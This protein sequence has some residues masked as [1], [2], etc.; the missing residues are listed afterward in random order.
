MN[1]YCNKKCVSYK[2][3]KTILKIKKKKSSTWGHPHF[4][5]KWWSIKN[6]S[7]FKETR[8]S[9]YRMGDQMWIDRVICVH[10]KQWLIWV[11][12]I[13]HQNRYPQWVAYQFR[14]IKGQKL[15]QKGSK[16]ESVRALYAMKEY[17]NMDHQPKRNLLLKLIKSLNAN[18][19]E[20]CFTIKKYYTRKNY[21]N[22][23]TDNRSER[24]AFQA[25]KKLKHD[26]Q[27]VAF[28]L[29]SLKG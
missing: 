13:Q 6:K 2:G 1:H 5:L 3:G 24:S 22:I 27:W 4:Y 11:I 7:W 25:K 8:M 15:S 10:V 19:D 17:L 29:Q 18:P 20:S 28:Q 26:S 21:F 12:L 9:P 16:F 23:N 14:N